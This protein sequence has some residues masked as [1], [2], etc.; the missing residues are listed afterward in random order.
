MLVTQEACI[1]IRH[2][3]LRLREKCH[4]AL[5]LGEGPGLRPAAE[6]VVWDPGRP[7]RQQPRHHALVGVGDHLWE[8]VASVKIGPG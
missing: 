6:L 8:G 7:G 3:R 5:E 2:P 4:T 1:A